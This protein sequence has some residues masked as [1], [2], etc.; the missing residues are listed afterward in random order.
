[1]A[2]I[3]LLSLTVYSR[4]VDGEEDDLLAEQV[5]PFGPF[6]KKHESGEQ[7]KI[8]GKNSA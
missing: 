4:A 8:N 6:L 1:M 3:V 2:C 5:Q 7:T